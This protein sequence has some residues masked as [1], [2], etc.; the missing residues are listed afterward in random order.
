MS[1]SRVLPAAIPG[2]GHTA[3]SLADFGPQSILALAAEPQRA[4]A[5]LIEPVEEICRMVGWQTIEMSERAGPD[6][7][8]TA[9]IRAVRRL[10]GQFNISLWDRERNRPR[11]HSSGPAISDSVGQAFA[12]ADLQPPLRVW[13]AGL[14]GG[15]SLAA[16]EAAL[17]GALCNPVA[18]YLPGPHQ[19]AGALTKE[20]QALRPDVILIVGGHE[21]IVCAEPTPSLRRADATDFAL[22]GRH[23]RPLSEA[24]TPLARRKQATWRSANSRSQEQVLALSRLVIEAAVELPA[25]DRPL[26]C[27]AGNSQ[28]ADTA[29]ASW[30]QRTGGGAAAAAD[31]VFNAT[32]SGSVSALHNVLERLHWQRSLDIPAMQEIAG[33]LDHS[34]ELSSTQWAFAQAVRLWRRRHRLPTLHGLYVAADRWLH[35]WAWEMPDQESEGLRTYCVRPG[36]CPDVLADWPP[37]RLVSGDWPAEWSRPLQPPPVLIP[38]RPRALPAYWWDPLG[39]VPVVAG[40]GRNAPDAVLQVLTADILL[41]DGTEFAAA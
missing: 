21:Q 7:C 10:E 39:L 32:D 28:S 38:Q 11:L 18:T 8:K 41:E 23:P 34:V 2:Q 3:D 13:M 40:V 1:L 33:W 12:V 27:F 6:E 29:L 5:V 24:Q 16:G 30:R 37:V 15:G 25:E 19:S 22:S 14:S 31:N 35:V 20:L 4:V 9:L 26:F 36:D 17:A